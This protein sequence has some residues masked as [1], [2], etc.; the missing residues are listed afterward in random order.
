MGMVD[1]LCVFVGRVITEGSES[2]EGVERFSIKFG[3]WKLFTIAVFVEYR[4]LGEKECSLKDAGRLH[5]NVS[6]V[7]CCQ[8]LKCK[9]Q[10]KNHSKHVQNGYLRKVRN[11]S[12][13]GV[14]G[15]CCESFT[16]AD[17]KPH[18]IVDPEV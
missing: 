14:C 15:D 8:K 10:N 3:E 6:C 13:L 12:I 16:L 1:S 4:E 9:K 2:V 18:V 5:F 17:E 11:F 7:K